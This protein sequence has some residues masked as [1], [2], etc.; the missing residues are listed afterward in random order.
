MYVHQVMGVCCV[1][2]Y[3]DGMLFE[4]CMNFLN[5]E[6]NKFEKKKFFKISYILRVSCSGGGVEFFF[7]EKQF[8]LISLFILC[9]F[10]FFFLKFPFTYWLNGRWLL[11]IVDRDSWDLYPL[12]PLFP[13]SDF[14]S[15]K[16]GSQ[17]FGGG[18]VSVMFFSHFMLFTTFLG[19][20]ILGIHNFFG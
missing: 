18:G 16:W 19:K 11:Q 8:F 9:Y 4:F 17:W 14:V 6:K 15:Q 10:Q 5:I 12:Y 13:C 7:L 1:I 20:K 3:I 2:F